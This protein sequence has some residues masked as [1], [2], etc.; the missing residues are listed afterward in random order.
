MSDTRLNLFYNQNNNYSIAVL[1]NK[2][3]K[4]SKLINKRF[5]KFI[6]QKKDFCDDVWTIIKEYLLDIK[7]LSSHF[8]QE[9]TEIKI[10]RYLYCECCNTYNTPFTSVLIGKRYNNLLQIA[11]YRENHTP[12]KKPI[13]KMYKT[14]LWVAKDGTMMEMCD[15]VNTQIWFY[16]ASYY[17]DDYYDWDEFGVRYIPRPFQQFLHIPSINVINRLKYIT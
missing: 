6:K 11:I 2:Y 4:Q 1:R 9:N 13:Y 3:K 12:I 15:E 7:Y 16:D 10:D 17:D 14:H 8:Y 5:G